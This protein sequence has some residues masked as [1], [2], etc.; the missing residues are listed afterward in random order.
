MYFYGENDYSIVKYMGV[1]KDVED[2]SGTLV[3]VYDVQYGATA[4]GT[5]GGNDGF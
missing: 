1:T 2:E 3:D 5:S 4:G